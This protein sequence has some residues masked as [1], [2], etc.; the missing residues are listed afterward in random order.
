MQPPTLEEWM[1]VISHLPNDKASGPSGS[2]VHFRYPKH[3]ETVPYYV[4]KCP[5]LSPNVPGHVPK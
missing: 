3:F 2:D 4:P 1:A 5:T